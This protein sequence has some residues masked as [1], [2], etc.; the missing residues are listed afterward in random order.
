MAVSAAIIDRIK[1]LIES[2]IPLSRILP[3]LMRLSPTPHHAV[4]EDREIQ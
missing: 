2:S 1:K 3:F 4:P